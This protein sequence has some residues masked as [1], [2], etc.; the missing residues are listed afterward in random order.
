MYGSGRV[1]AVDISRVVVDSIDIVE[2]SSSYIRL[3]GVAN[4]DTFITC[5]VDGI[6]NI[7]EELF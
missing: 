6:K 7:V 3:R 4:D 2:V 1:L 5:C